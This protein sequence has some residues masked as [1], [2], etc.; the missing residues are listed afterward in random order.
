MQ[1]KQN[2]ISNHKYQRE[3]Y[4]SRI[5]RV[6]DYIEANIDSNLTLED[7][8]KV[9]HFSQFH[10]HRIFRAMVGETLNQFIQRIRIEKAGSQLILNPKKTVTEIAFDCGFTGSACFARAFKEHFNMNASTWRSGGY[11]KFSK[12]SKVDSNISKTLSKD[13]KDH[14]HFSMYINDVNVTDGAINNYLTSQTWRKQMDKKTKLQVEVKDIEP[15]HVAY[16]RHIGPYKGDSKLFEGLFNKLF[17]WAGPRGLIQPPKTKILSVYHDSPEITDEDKL[18]T[19][20]CITVPK[21]TPTEGEVGSMDIPGGKY[22][23]AHFEIDADGYQEAWDSVF[24]VWL[25]DS[26]YQPDDRPSFELC[27]NNPKEHPEGKHIIDIC[28]PVKPM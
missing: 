17:T 6:I 20:I 12:I 15:M 16:V 22:A 23:F 9:A 5:N 14:N 4:I 18:R 3:E 25:P 21:G 2:N 27:H 26:G 19:S 11:R 10:F 8:A 13:S 1:K 24:R 7:L 28:V